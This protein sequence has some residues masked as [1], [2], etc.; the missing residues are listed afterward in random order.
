MT[1]PA[2]CILTGTVESPPSTPVSGALVRV[3]TIAT[4]L[5]SNGAGAAVNDLTTTTAADGTWSLTLAQGL[6][7]QIDIPIVGVASDITVPALTTADLS[8]LTLYAR[9]TLTPATIISATGPSM[10]GDL[11][12]SSPNP[13]VVGLRG[14]G[15]HADTPADGKVWVYRSASGDYRLESFPVSSAVQTVTAGQG[16]TVTGTTNPTV[17]VTSGGVVAGM[18]ASG[19][20]ASNVGT[21]GGD[22]SGTLPSPQ[23]AAGAIVDADVN[24]AANIAWTKVSKSGAAASDVGAVATG[25][26]LAAINAS[27]ETPKIAAG[28]LAGGIAQ[29]QVTNLVT[30]LAAKRNTAD[31]IAQADVT[32][33][34]SDLAG[35]QAISEKGAVGGYAGLDGTG[36]VPVAQLPP[37]VL[38]DGDR[39]DITVSSGGTVFTIDSAAVTY[40]KIQNV[41][42]TD[43]LLGRASSGAGTIE[44]VVCTAAGRAL[45]DD[46]SAADQ[47]TTLGLGTAAVLNVPAIGDAAVT[48]VVK[49]TDTRLTDA[50]TPTAHTHAEADVTGLVSDLAAKVPTSRSIST[51]SPLAGGGALSGDLTLTVGDAS[52][53]AKGVVMLTG[54]LGGTATSPTVANVGGQPAA[55]VAAGSVLANA[56]TNANTASA[57]VRRD[58]SG[59]FSAGTITANVTG[60]VSGTAANVTGTVAIANGGTGQTTATAAFDALAPTS[61]KGDLI[62]YNGTDNVRLPVGADGLALVAD[63]STATGL[64]YAT[65]A[66][67]SVTSVATGNGLQGGPIT[68]TGTVDLRLNAA[69]GLT[70]TLGGGGNELGIAA[71][72]VTDA[73]LAVAKVPAARTLTTTAPLTIDGGASA[74]LSANRTLAVS[75]ATAGAKGIVQLA[76]D[77]SGTAAAPTVATVGGQTA[78]NVAAGA[79]LANAA[80]SANTASTIVRRDASGNFA[81]GTVTASLTGD[82]TGNV[83]GNVSGNVT[84][85]ATGA[86]LDKGGAIYNVKAYGAQGDGSFDDTTAINSAIAAMGTG[87]GILY[88]PK[89]TYKFST[90]TLGGKGMVVRGAGWGS[91]TLSTTTTGGTG[92]LISAA[93]CGIEDVSVQVTGTPVAGQKSVRVT[94]SATIARVAFT[95]AFL[96]ISA[97]GD[98]ALRDVTIESPDA[99]ALALVNVVS[100]G[101]LDAERVAIG[102]RDAPL[103]AGTGIAFGSGTAPSRIV[104]SGVFMDANG[105]AVDAGSIAGL[106][107]TDSVLMGAGTG[108]ALS[109]AGGTVTIANSQAWGGTNAVKVTGT[110]YLTATSCQF[111]SDDTNVATATGHTVSLNTDG[112]T[113]FADVDLGHA[114]ATFSD[115]Y[116]PNASAVLYYNGGVLHA[117][118]ALPAAAYGVNW[119]GSQ[120]YLSNITTNGVFGTAAFTGGSL[121]GTAVAS[122][123]SI[124]ITAPVT[125]V[126]GTTTVNTISAPVSTGPITLIPDGAFAL[127]TAGNIAVAMTATVG[128][129]I[130][131]WYDDVTGKWYPSSRLA[132]T[133]TAG[134]VLVGNGT[135]NVTNSADLVWDDANSRLGVGVAAPTQDVDVAGDVRAAGFRLS[136]LQTAPSSAADTGTTGELRFVDGYLYLA[137]GT[138]QWKRVALTTWP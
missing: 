16:I 113:V 55:N 35:K 135:N 23:I 19:A 99:S 116:V 98:V 61:A 114:A 78:A 36:K 46:A 77:I 97:E 110:S 70:K 121:R 104:S 47:R 128:V 72:G 74:D 27:I 39:G 111:K 89:G 100:P 137:V 54:D 83:T 48:E 43:R 38:A 25:T 84:G 106:R 80:T 18:L 63:A 69:G 20:A 40:A 73:M 28:Q 33:L 129:P 136:A 125:H 4:Q 85:N 26:V 131:L 138:N 42:A 133:L 30:D 103:T 6:K 109:I 14:K 91:T 22:L 65:P 56:A 126:T 81:A 86:L 108:S 107:I 12:G 117:V 11:T 118:S 101:T 21:L 59:N 29:S 15:L 34:V 124:S 53:A 1:A 68:T 2:T 45:L 82:V 24:A 76:G 67:G 130:Q 134:R 9:G 10:G 94:G 64:K 60:N 31:A 127:S 92:I 93:L 122:A 32:N 66:S 79:A 5:L 58:A 8:T 57:I 119:A 102:T 132:G 123:A 71:G 41:A 50:R 90:F 44:E 17:A 62:V 87:K 105:T 96:A 13:T 51:T 52:G 3:R 37:A 95:N 120:A 112:Q 7:A 49:G 75:D 115:L 88:F